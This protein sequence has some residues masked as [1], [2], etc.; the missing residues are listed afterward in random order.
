MK[1]VTISPKYNSTITTL[2]MKK[3]PFYKCNAAI[4]MINN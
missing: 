3:E 4:T 1:R 2:S